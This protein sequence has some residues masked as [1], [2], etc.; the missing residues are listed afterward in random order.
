MP[1]TDEVMPKTDQVGCPDD[2]GATAWRRF[3]WPD[4][5]TPTIDPANIGRA[6]RAD[7]A[8]PVDLRVG[9]TAV[10]RI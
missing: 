8:N 1:R 6:T 9:N 10:E 4:T 3:A 7:L 2:G 5:R